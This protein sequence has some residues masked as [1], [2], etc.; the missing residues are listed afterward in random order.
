M[1]RRTANLG[2]IIGLG[3]LLLLCCLLPY[4]VSSVYSILGAVLQVPTAPTWLW[5]EW[6]N[7]LAEGND[8][9]YMLLTEGPIC[10]AGMAALLLIVFGLVVV[11]GLGSRGAAEEEAVLYETA[12]YDDEGELPP[13]EPYAP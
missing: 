10:G 9:L 2:C 11:L 8:T 6:V 7:R 13:A 5:G 12:E 1:E 3:G 4:L